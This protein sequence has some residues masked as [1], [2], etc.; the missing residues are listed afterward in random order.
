MLVLEVEDGFK[1]WSSIRWECSRASNEVV[2][3]DEAVSNGKGKD[4]RNGG[5]PKRRKKDIII[6]T[7]DYEVARVIFIK[8]GLLDSAWGHQCVKTVEIFWLVL[9]VYLFDPTDGQ[10]VA[11]SQMVHEQKGQAT[12]STLNNRW[13]TGT[14][15]NRQQRRTTRNNASLAG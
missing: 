9:L 4:G 2:G 13:A 8:L 14:T 10:I 15:S 12:Y 11:S 1:Y 3:P 5:W 7:F 6:I